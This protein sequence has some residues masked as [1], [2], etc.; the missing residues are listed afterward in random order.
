VS[1]E[2]R[3]RCILALTPKAREILDEIW[4]EMRKLNKR[5]DTR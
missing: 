3:G 5:G 1:Q 4:L 2:K